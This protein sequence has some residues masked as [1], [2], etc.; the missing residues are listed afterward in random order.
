[1]P[2]VTF[3]TKCW[4]GDFDK[5]LGGAFDRKVTAIG[6]PFDD[7]VLVL[8][9]GIPSDIPWHRSFINAVAL[10]EELLQNIG[11]EEE[12]FRGG[13]NYA[14]GELAAVW[15]TA[16]TYLCFVQGDCITQGGD[17]VTPGIQLLEREKNVVVV[18]PAS[19]V[20]TW[21]DEKG[22]DHYMSDQ[23]FLVRTADFH[24]PEL[25]SYLGT[26]KDYPDYGGLSFEHLIGNYLKAT[27]KKRKILKSFY[28]LHPTY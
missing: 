24:N 3:A 26:D 18:S 5:F 2:T 23:A 15:Y 19:E 25:Y 17:W 16:S 9:N 11:R 1:M 13:L 8:N 22:Y 27:G 21:H 20:N 10:K 6:Y 4:G 14:L 7:S 28:V 12:D